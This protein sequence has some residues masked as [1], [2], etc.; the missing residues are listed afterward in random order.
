[1]RE[2][3]DYTLVILFGQ[4]SLKELVKNGTVHMNPKKKFI[5]TRRFFSEKK[6]RD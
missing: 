1:M 3:P 2:A 4:R 6:Q 5:R